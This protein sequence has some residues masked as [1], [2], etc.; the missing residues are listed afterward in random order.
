MRIRNREEWQITEAPSERIAKAA[1]NELAQFF[2][3]VSEPGGPCGTGL[4]A[5]MWLAELDNPAVRVDIN[6][7]RAFREVTIRT[8]SRLFNGGQQ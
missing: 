2:S 3:A 8:L 7:E 5:D 6:P 4:I 1:E